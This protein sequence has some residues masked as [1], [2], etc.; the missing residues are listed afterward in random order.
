MRKYLIFPI[1]SLFIALAGCETTDDEAMTIELASPKLKVT[2]ELATATVTWDPIAKT[3]GYAYAL[4]QSADYVQLG[5]D[6]TTVTLTQLAKGSHTFRIKAVGNLEHTTDSA[7]RTIDFEIDP[8]LEAPKP[9]YVKGEAMGSV[10]IS[11]DAVKGAAGYAYKLDDDASWTNVGADVLSIVKEGLN[12]EETHTFTMYAVGKLPDSSDSEEASLSFK[13]V[14]TSEGVWIRM[15]NGELFE[16]TESETGIFTTTISCQATDSFDVLIQNVTYGFTSYSGNGGVG[17]VNNTQAC[18]PFYNYPTAVY[19][20][21]QSVGQMTA[22]V[23]DSPINKFWINMDA[24][25]EIDVRIDCTQEM[26]RY[27]LQL[28]EA[29]DPSLVLAQY[30]DLMVF[31]GDWIQTGKLSKSGL[32][33]GATD[34]AVLDGTEP[35]TTDAKYTDFGA[36]IASDATASPAYLANRDLTGWGIAYCFEF[37]GY[38]RLSNT[39]SSSSGALYYGVLTTPTLTALTSAS[40][41]TLTFDAVRFATTTNIPVKVLGAGTITAASVQIE[42]SSSQTA[43]TPTSDGKSIEITSVHCPK[44]GNEELK[45]WSNFTVTIEGATAETQISWDT[46][47]VGES[48][49]DGRICLD[50]IVIRK[51]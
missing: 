30:F 47:G 4:D 48:S 37:P 7:E 26:P 9:S 50:N 3:A 22:K 10:T 18:V 42:G 32:K 19:Y 23:D 33:T 6:V 17:T 29:E 28:V 40:T 44:H 13:L 41:V 25:C 27:K 15:N 36:N 35:G 14:D 11:W 38:V 39:A 51:N 45:A 1:V 31:G 16:T 20:V 12:V 34:T 2:T 49:K 5:A 43:I 21:R 46:T 8:T 24:A